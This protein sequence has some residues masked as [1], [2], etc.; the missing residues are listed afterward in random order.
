MPETIETFLLNDEVDSNGFSMS[1]DA[2]KRGARKWIGTPGILYEKCDDQGCKF[3]HT[4]GRDLAE[5]QQLSQ[6]HKVS[7]I[8]D[9]RIDEKTHTLFAIQNITS[10]E[11][12]EKIC[13]SEIQYVSQSIWLDTAPSNPDRVHVTST[14]YTPVHLAHITEP[15][16]D[17]DVARITVKPSCGNTK[18]SSVQS[19]N[20]E[21][22]PE[23]QM[24]TDDM[25]KEMYGMMKSMAEPKEAPKEEP[26]EEPV[27][28]PEQKQES[29]KKSKYSFG[30]PKDSKQES[31]LLEDLVA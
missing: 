4:G 30:W 9:V 25:V 27:K 1:W 19:S 23:Q 20:M 31:N 2:I 24:S 16:F 3:E 14:N 10:S 29:S 15:A 5:A 22:E 17:E 26:K 12:A 8:V 21:P 18:K 6:Q 11:F 28:E 13:S 7:E